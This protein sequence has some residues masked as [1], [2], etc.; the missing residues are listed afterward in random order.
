[1]SQAARTLSAPQNFFK[2]IESLANREIARRIV[3]QVRNSN[4]PDR[5]EA[6]E[7]M[8]AAALDDAIGPCPTLSPRVAN[9]SHI[10][11]SPGVGTP[12]LGDDHLGVG[13]ALGGAGGHRTFE[14]GTNVS[15][16]QGRKVHQLLRFF[17]RSLLC[18]LHMVRCVILKQELCN[19]RF[20]M[21]R[22]RQPRLDLPQA[23]RRRRTGGVLWVR[24]VCRE[25]R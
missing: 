23:A 10:E 7:R 15:R 14:L 1:M 19:G 22:L 3:A 24:S 9:A 4:S 13:G 5:Y 18:A 17:L 2:S 6:A 16:R 21:F 8:I 12:G 11:E 25:L 20:R